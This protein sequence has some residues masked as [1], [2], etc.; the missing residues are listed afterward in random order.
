MPHRFF[1]LFDDVYV[2]KRWHLGSPLDAQGKEVDDFG[3]FTQGHAVNDPGQLRM[4]FDVP[5]KPLDY[6][7]GG[8]NVPVLHPRVA[9]VFTE[10]APNDVQLLPVRLEEQPEPYFILVVTRRVRCIDEQASEVERW[11]AEEGL[12]EMVGQYRFVSNLHLDSSRIG[13]AR[14]FRPEGWEVVIVISEEIKE[15]LERIRATGVKFTEVPC[16]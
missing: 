16:T 12:P 1:R 7:L 5:G 6:S 4:S 11:T 14:V 3:Y 13:D 9:Q 15:A 10:L 8:V 2:P